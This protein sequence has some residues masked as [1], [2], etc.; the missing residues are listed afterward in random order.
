[1]GSSSSALY[2][3]CSVLALTLSFAGCTGLKSSNPPPTAA[4]PVTVALNQSL[5]SI[6]E[7]ATTQFRATVKGS[8]NTAVLW[9][10]DGV[11]GGGPTAGTISTSGLYTAP[12]LTGS[13]TVTATSVAESSS[14]AKAAVT[15]VSGVAVSPSFSTLETEQTQQFSATLTALSDT[16]YRSRCKWQSC[17]R[18]REFFWRLS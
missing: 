2:L 15:V 11:R 6:A 16:A 3:R 9:A 10:V 1:M 13:H 4:T 12:A 18:H 17:R 5:V 14:I 7:G 8:T